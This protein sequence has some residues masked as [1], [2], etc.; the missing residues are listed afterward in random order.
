MLDHEFRGPK[1]SF[2][3]DG[4]GKVVH[5]GVADGSHAVLYALLHLA[6]PRVVNGSEV[7]I[8]ANPAVNG[9]PAY[10]SNLGGLGDGPAFNQ[11]LQRLLLNRTELNLAIRPIC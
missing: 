6:M 4:V 5:R 10:T 9:L 3:A 7:H 2:E 8:F 11:M 1:I